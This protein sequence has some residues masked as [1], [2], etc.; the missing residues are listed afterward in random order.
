LREAFD[1][2]AVV[3]CHPAEGADAEKILL[4]AREMMFP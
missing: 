1:H 3:R 4:A 2:T